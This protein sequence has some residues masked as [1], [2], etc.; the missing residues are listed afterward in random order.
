MKAKKFLKR[1]LTKSMTCGCINTI[2]CLL[3]R[4][5]LKLSFSHKNAPV[6]RGHFVE[7]SILG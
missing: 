6:V 5:K 3:V 2:H 7:N 1:S 4:F